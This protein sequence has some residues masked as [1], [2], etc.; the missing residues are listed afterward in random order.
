[1]QVISVM[2]MWTRMQPS[3]AANMWNEALNK[4]LGTEVYLNV[5][6]QYKHVYM[7]I[8]PLISFTLCGTNLTQNKMWTSH[9][10][11]DLS[12]QWTQKCSWCYSLL[13]NIDGKS[14][15]ILVYYNRFRWNFYMAFSFISGFPFYIAGKIGLSGLFHENLRLCFNMEMV[16]SN[17]KFF[18]VC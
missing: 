10:L 9:V 12:C 15:D 8:F 16:L 14:Q 3:Y 5:V 4:R 6:L 17:V 18:Q 11:W 2:S 1:M 7:N 13:S